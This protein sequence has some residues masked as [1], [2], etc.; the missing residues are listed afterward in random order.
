LPNILAKQQA[1]EAKAFEAILIKNGFVTEGSSSNVMIYEGGLVKT[2][3]LDDSILPGVTRQEIIEI[4]K[5]EGLKVQ[6][7]MI[8]QDELEAANEVFL[9][10]TTIEVL[11]VT[12]LDGKPVGPGVPGK[13]TNLLARKFEALIRQ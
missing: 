3:P 11:P 8:S 13:V 9:V 6:E 10:G 4:A 7:D 2:P 5:M 1:T 12:T